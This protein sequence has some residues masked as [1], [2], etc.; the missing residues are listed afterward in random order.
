MRSE[1]NYT[2][3][4][5]VALGSRREAV[6]EILVPL[7]G[8]GDVVRGRLVKPVKS[9]RA[10]DNFCLPGSENQA[11]S[12]ADLNV[13]ILPLNFIANFRFGGKTPPFFL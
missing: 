2:V 9:R 10:G 6:A 3:G 7:F 11:R 13:V 5:P 12:Q 1:N 8:G 4:W